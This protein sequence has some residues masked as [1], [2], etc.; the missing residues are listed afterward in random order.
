MA[1][2]GVR[3]LVMDLG[4][5]YYEDSLGL[6]DREL[7]RPLGMVLSGDE[8]EMDRG[9]W[10]HCG[11]VVGGRLVACASLW[12]RGY[13]RAQIKQVVVDPEVRGLGLG[14]G[15]MGYAEEEARALGVEI[16]YVHARHYVVSFYEHLGYSVVGEAFNEVGMEHYVM[17]KRLGTRD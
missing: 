15:I 12:L 3:Y 9:G 6:R 5:G 11:G 13:G 2:E 7:R 16:V 14:C 1:M 4:S 10:R 17:E 8:R